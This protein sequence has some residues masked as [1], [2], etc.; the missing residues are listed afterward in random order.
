MNI[1]NNSADRGL[2]PGLDFF[3]TTGLIEHVLSV[4]IMYHLKYTVLCKSHSNANRVFIDK[5]FTYQ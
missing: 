3:S 4:L 5:I 2:L 1:V